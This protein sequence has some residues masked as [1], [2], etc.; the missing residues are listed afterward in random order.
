MSFW[1]GLVEIDGRE[2]EE[3]EEEEEV[4][5]PCKRTKTGQ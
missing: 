3:E 1:Q 4:V 2:E 5:E